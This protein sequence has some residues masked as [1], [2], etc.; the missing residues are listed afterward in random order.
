M[1]IEDNIENLTRG[2]L[3][4]RLKSKTWKV[5]LYAYEELLN[6]LSESGIDSLSSYKEEFP[7][8]LEDKHHVSL[9]KGLNFLTNYL[10]A[11]SESTTSLNTSK[12]FTLL[13]EKVLTSIKPAVKNSAINL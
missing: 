9:E 7:K 13:I 3:K 8:I 11:E 2:P 4:N 6:I 1:N 12:L 5:R 10:E